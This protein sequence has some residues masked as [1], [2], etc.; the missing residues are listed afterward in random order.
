MKVKVKTDKEELCFLYND[1]KMLKDVTEMVA[2]SNFSSAEAR[3][4]NQGNNFALKNVLK[5][6]EE[7]VTN[8]GK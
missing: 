7:R 3:A 2:R 6:I 1:V 8:E 4:F 5:L